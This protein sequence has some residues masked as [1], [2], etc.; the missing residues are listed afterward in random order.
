MIHKFTNIH[1]EAKIAENVTIEAFSTVYGNVEIG[2]DT[3]IG[4]NVTIMDGARIGKNC[5]IFP[6]AVLSAIPQ[7]LKFVGE[8][9]QTV[10]GNN[11]TIR[12]CVTINRGTNTK[13]LTQIGNNNLLMAYVHVAHDCCIGNNCIIVN[14]VGIAGE[15]IIDD[16]VYIG[17]MS[18]VQ[19]FSHIGTQVMIAGGS[20]VRKDVPPYLKAAREPLSFIGIN[21]IGLK[22]RNFELDKIREI[23]EIYRI[24]Y[25]N[26]LNISQA[27][28]YLE[29]N[30]AS[31]DERNEII[32]FIKTSKKGII[33]GCN[34]ENNTEYID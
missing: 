2:E 1:P 10:I 9:T 21:H 6:G 14:N 29:N 12:E 11:N 3:W 27:T 25:K 33:R 16:H 24:I 30:F 18:A 23:Q 32:N 17:G 34:L 8:I 7:D 26:G 5:K 4:S 28:E 31:T 15:A 20:R 13:K 19:Q 22:R